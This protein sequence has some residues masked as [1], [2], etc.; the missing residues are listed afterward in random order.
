MAT[1]RIRAGKVVRTPVVL[2][3][4]SFLMAVMEH[5]TSWREDMLERLGSFRPVV[6][7][8]VYAELTRLAAGRTRGARYASLAKGMVD[9]GELE[10]QESGG[11]GP[12]DDELISRALE[13]GALVATLDNGL[14]RQLSSSKVPVLRL[15][16][17][18]VSGR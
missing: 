9:R 6:I 2:F 16:G 15:S 8:P 14:I 7:K 4:T 17:G 1:H 12:A 18:R 13:G 5:P 3:D 10:L 11:D